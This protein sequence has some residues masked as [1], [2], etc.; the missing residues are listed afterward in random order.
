MDAFY[1]RIRPQSASDIIDIIRSM[2]LA[3]A[4]ITAPF[5][6]EM[7]NLVDVV[8]L[9]AKEIGAINTVV[10][11]DGRLIGYNTDHYGVTQSLKEGNVEL[12]EKKCL[13]LG[14]GGA[15]RSVVYGLKFKGA[16]VTVCNRSHSKAKIIA[17]DFRCKR[18]DW[19]NFDSSKEFDVVV[20][21]LPS[22]VL[23]PFFEQLKFHTLLDASYKQ[24]RISELSISKGHTVITGKR[25]LLHQAIEAF[26]LITGHNP[27]LQ[28]MGEALNLD[29]VKGNLNI[30][31]H[32]TTEN[33][34]LKL[35][36]VDLIISTKNLTD[37]N[38]KV[39]IDE[40]ISKAFGD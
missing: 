25:W 7:L 5:K 34:T 20:S 33:K 12:L 28:T 21:T 17:N 1:T 40:E 11:S 23:P 37:N 29:L 14:G 8:S 22:N 36:N 38:I 2:P 32:P 26:R 27:Q 24:S 35:E 19:N 18:I 3:G 9:D 30:L 39:I 6:E 4:N 10:N 15:A 13:V 16:Q 31:E